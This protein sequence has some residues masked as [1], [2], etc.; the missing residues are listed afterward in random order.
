[1]CYS[2][3]WDEAEGGF[4]CSS[5]TDACTDRGWVTQE[6]ILSIINSTEYE[7]E[8]IT[9]IST[10]GHSRYSHSPYGLR[11]RWAGS[12]DE[13]QAVLPLLFPWSLPQMPLGNQSSYSSSS[14]GNS[15]G[16][17]LSIFSKYHCGIPV[18]VYSELNVVGENWTGRKVER[19]GAGPKFLSLILR[20]GSCWV[21][22]SKQNNK[23]IQTDL[24]MRFSRSLKCKVAT[25]M[26][27]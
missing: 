15:D 1:M 2:R 27:D 6:S 20:Y 13:Y 8:N 5:S 4:R 26:A 21:K 22:E 9:A 12:S 10:K 17:N 25:L 19:S 23:T 18:P 11:C 16:N 3:I 24:T 7:F 14:L